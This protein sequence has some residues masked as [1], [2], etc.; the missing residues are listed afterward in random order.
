MARN[1]D[2]TL[3][4]FE[5]A[6]DAPLGASLVD[7]AGACAEPVVKGGLRQRFDL[8]TGPPN[9]TRMYDV[10][11]NRL[12]VAVTEESPFTIDLE[13]PKAPMVQNG[14]MQLRV[15]ATRREGF[16]APITVRMLRLP[17]GV[18]SQPTIAI[19][20]GES[21]AQYLL[22]ASNE[23][24]PGTY[25]LAVLGEAESGRGVVLA[26][27]AL[28]PI[29][30]QPPFLS[31]RLELAAVEQGKPVQ[32]IGT[33]EPATPFEGVGTV[34]LRGLPAKCEAAERQISASDTQ[35]VFD[36]TTAPD[37]PAGKHTSLFCQVQVP[38]G[39]ESVLHNTGGGGV[40]RVDPP[41][42][43]PKAAPPQPAPASEPAKPAEPDKQPV[44]PLS[45]LEQL[46]LE[47]QKRAN[48]EAAGEQGERAPEPEGAK[49]GGGLRR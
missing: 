43:P 40:L 16:D 48:P 8:V 47:A 45:R 30:I 1:T 21:E 38:V 41:P 20:Q 31:L 6:A 23:T 18:G 22:N 9:D 32:V 27:S 29:T 34:A 2:T 35:V 49:E 10:S 12:A 15:R 46:R 19:G 11:V 36:V 7:L 14:A 33:I 42:P 3:L 5:A 24:A 4:L 26:A 39:G 37:T 28:T 13:P 17:P 44:K 25:E